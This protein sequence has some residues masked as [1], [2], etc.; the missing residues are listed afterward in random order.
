MKRTGCTFRR[1]GGAALIFLWLWTAPA[2]GDVITGADWRVVFNH[3]DQTTTL[4]SIGANEFDI[5]EAFVERIEALGAGDQGYLATYTLTGGYEA[6]GA[7]GPILTAVSNALARGAYMGFAVGS[8]VDLAE[9]FQPGCSL[10]SLSRRPGNALE[11]ARAPSK[12]IMHHKIGVFFYNGTGEGR[13]LTASWNFTA[14]ASSRQWN[15]LADFSSRDLALAYSNELR[16]L[17]NGYFHSNPAKSRVP[18]DKAAFRTAAAGEDG[19]VRF[20]PYPSGR[21]GGDNAQTEITNRIA[22]ARQSIWFALNK[23]TRAVVTDQL[24]AACDRGVAVHGV[25]P[26]SDR[27]TASAASYGQFQRMLDASAYATTNRIQLHEAYY[28]STSTEDFDNGLSDLVHCKYMVIDP[29]GESPW[30]I[31]GSANWTLTALA[32]TNT[33][34]SNDENILFIPDGGIARA[35]LAQFEAMTGIEAIEPEPGS[36]VRLAVAPTSGGRSELRFTLPEGVTGILVGTADPRDWS[37]PVWSMSVGEGAHAI[38]LTNGLPRM[39]FRLEAGTP[40][41]SSRGPA[42]LSPRRGSGGGAQPRTNGVLLEV[43][44]EPETLTALGEGG[45]EYTVSAT[46]ANDT[47][48]DITHAEWSVVPADGM[49]NG[50]AGAQ[51]EDGETLVLV[52]APEDGGREFDVGYLVVAGEGDGSATNSAACRLTVLNPRRVDFE[53]LGPFSSYPT[54]YTVDEATGEPD[55]IGITTNLNGMDWMLFNLRRSETNRIG[56]YSARLRHSSSRLPGLLESRGA[57][58]GVG[59]ISVNYALYSTTGFLTFVIETQAAESGEWLPAG[60][61]CRVEAGGDISNQ[62]YTVDVN[63]PG[64]HRVRLRTTGGYGKVVNIDNLIIRPHGDLV[65]ALAVDGGP[66]AAIGREYEL[67]FRLDNAEGAPRIW[68]DYGAVAADAGDAPVLAEADGQLRLAFTPAPEDAGR[69]FT[70]TGTVSVYGGQYV[71]STSRTFTV[72]SAPGFELWNASPEGRTVLFTNEILDVWSTNVFL[73]G[74]PCTNR[75]AYEAQWMAYPAFAT[76]TVRDYNR[77][78]IGGG[79][80]A[81]D[82]GNHELFLTLTDKSNGLATTHSLH[83]LVLDRETPDSRHLDFEDFAETGYEPRT[84]TLS[85]GDWDMAGIRAGWETRDACI[86]TTAARIQCPGTG[87]A[88]LESRDSFDGIG[89]IEFACAGHAGTEGGAVQVQVQAEGEAE[90]RPVGASA[91][92][93]ADLTRHR[94]YAGV[95]TQARV[96]IEVSGPAGSLINVDE[97]SIGAFRSEERIVVNGAL[98]IPAG[99]GF[100]LRF[101]PADLAAGVTAEGIEVLR[102]GWDV[103]QYDGETPR[104][105]LT[106]EGEAGGRAGEFL[107][108]IPLSSGYWLE[109]NVEWTVRA[110]AGPGI[111]GFRPGTLSVWGL[112]GWDLVVF[113]FTNLTGEAA[114]PASWVWA[115]TNLHAADG[116]EEIELPA[117]E[118]PSA[119]GRRILFYGVKTQ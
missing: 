91:I 62:M 40:S 64:R 27:D 59:S 93:I 45:V 12:G 89:Y 22:R 103:T 43:T 48:M 3:P 114:H 47:G 113:A 20:A 56:A 26:R 106:T 61:P 69:T 38:A 118:D 79:L 58:S 94:V 57:F 87:A 105:A 28:K 88:F 110:A 76:N 29:F 98:E 72:A 63:R 115:I 104:F 102:N 78:R 9:E 60:E 39:F 74:E 107:I 54:N 80:L 17:L 50:F 117:A 67:R 36:G 25:I 24:I 6:N 21:T 119:A 41:G 71:Y 32:T 75:D 15:I 19:W 5:R 81:A 42:D 46:V 31:H 101:V 82:I 51:A 33:P 10:D 92:P 7:A 30:V 16:Q 112:A 111:E 66:F 100:D 49:T 53:T 109:T 44:L 34:T 84:A 11:V 52:P 70:A 14:W 55:Y 116:V 85:G 108:R 73:G 1:N 18:H 96:R 86:G 4:T 2:A 35:F 13:L 8:G 83:F 68:S 77:Y 95:E 65:P 90:F 97:V 99:G 23:Q 37:L